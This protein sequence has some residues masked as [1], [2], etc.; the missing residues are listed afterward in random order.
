VQA[1][2][3]LLFAHPGVSSAIVGTI[4]RCT[5]P[6]TWPP[7]PA[8]WASLSHRAGPDARRSLVPR[9]LIRKN[10]SNFKTLPLHVEATPKA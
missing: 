9:T 2:F 10:P 7:S 4:N 5:W 1:S 6:T 3:E 8:S